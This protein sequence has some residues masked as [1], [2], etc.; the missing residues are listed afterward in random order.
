MKFLAHPVKGIA[1][2]LLDADLEGE[3]L[4][5]H[6]SEVGPGQRSHQK[7]TPP[8]QPM[9]FM[10][11]STAVLG[12]EEAIVYPRQGKMVHYEGE[13]AVIIAKNARRV[14]EED[15][16]DYVFGYTC[17]ND[18]SERVIQA[19]EMGNGCLLI[20]KGFDTFKPL[21]PYI[22]TELDPANLE[23]TTRL[24]GEVK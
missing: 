3:P 21:G 20:G 14:A 2:C 8:A 1:R 4:H 9:L 23:L 24:N 15:T 19:A 16:L 12:P 5:V 6:I 10:L 13:V 11:L 7:A 17:S 18:V 22:A